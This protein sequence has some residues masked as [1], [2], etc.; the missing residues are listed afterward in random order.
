[1][2]GLLVAAKWDEIVANT[3]KV[4]NQT[5]TGDVTGSVALTIAAGVVD[6][7]MLSDGVDGELITWDAAGVAATVLVGTVG[8]ILTSGGVGVAPTFQDR[9]RRFIQVSGAGTA[10]VIT[11]TPITMDLTTSDVTTGTGDFTVA[12]DAVTILNAGT[13]RI[14]AQCTTVD[15]DAAGAARTTIETRVEVN[16]AAVAGSIARHYH[17]ETE[18]NTG[19]IEFFYTVSANDVIRVRLDRLGQTTN[20]ETLPTLCKLNIELIS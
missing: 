1:M 8:Q 19:N 18:D 7:A 16:S 4:T 15:T 2:A 6:V 13:Y 5:H 14:F 10:Q 3:A 9:L 12:A 17:R 20:V 11:G